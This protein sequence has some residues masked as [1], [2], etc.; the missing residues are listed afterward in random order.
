MKKMLTLLPSFFLMLTAVLHADAQP[1]PR[2]VTLYV[3]R[4]GNDSW[5]GT[6]QVPNPARTDGP[7]ATLLGA[8]NAVR[9][10]RSHNSRALPV[11]VV[12]ASGSYPQRQPVVFEPQ[13]GGTAQCPISYEAA[14]GAKPVFEAGV[15]INGFRRGAYGVWTANVPDV[16][17]GALYFEQLYIN[18]RR[19]TRARLPK[20]F[21]YF[22]RGKY[23][24]GIDPLTGKEAALGGRA[25]VADAK[26]FAPLLRVPQDRLRDVEFIAYHSWEASWHRIAGL[27][28][29]AHAI[30]AMPP[31]AP[32]AFL[33]WAPNQR[34][35]IENL[36]EA[37]TDPGEWYLDRDG[38]LSY[39]PLPGEDMTK[40]QIY[41]PIGEQ[42][43]RFEG[44][45]AHKV[46]Y[47]TLKGLA[48]RHGGY[49]LPPEG[50]GDGQAAVGISAV[51]MADHA[52]HIIVR[53]CEITNVGLYGIWFRRGCTECRVQHTLFQDL[54]AG[55][56]RIG[57]DG[58]DAPPDEAD[59]TGHITLD[60]NIIRSGGRI[61]PGCIGVWIG[62]S[63]DNQ[64]IHNDIS[65]LYYT[66]ISVGWR[67]GYAPSVAKRN[68]IEFNH[69]H[70][71]GQGVMSDMGGVYT[72]GP[73]EGTTVSN[74]VIHD[75]YSY[76]R[77][78]RGGWGLYNDEGSTGI[79]EE[80][81]LVYNVKTGMYH[82]HYGR[83]NLLRNNIFAYSMDG[84]LQ[85]SRVEDHLS[86][87]LSH[88]IILWKESPLLSGSWGDA[89]VK[90]DHNLYWNSSGAKV[91][92]AG[93]TL[94]EWQATG[95]DEGSRVA[96]PDFVAPE[97]GDFRLKPGSP[98][99]QMGFKPFD[100][101]H[102]GVYGDA[103]WIKQA[104]SW[105][106]PPVRF[107]PPPPPSPPLAIHQDFER[108]PIGAPCPDAQNN[109]EGKGDSITVTDETANSGKRSLK[110][111][112]AP[113]L[114]FDFNPHLVF[115]PDHQAGVTTMKFAIRVEAG[116]FMYHEWRDWR[117]APY[118]VGPTF[119]IRNGVLTAAG[120]ELMPIPAGK[121]VEYT[122]RADVGPQQN[123]VWEL[124]VH[125]QGK[126]EHRFTDLPLGSR[127][128]RVL[129]WIGFS[130]MAT[131]RTVFYLD[132]IDLTSSK[133]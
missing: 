81:N 116:V 9:A 129:T 18:G 93:K 36:R 91:D 57:E 74:N 85:R 12:F 1:P 14:P 29:K 64:V 27:D 77:Y 60:N 32:W 89:N 35:V 88:N 83:E 66:G 3:A 4:N 70:H 78:G 56:A 58:G 51:V 124:T 37:L 46:A 34:Y 102:A 39:I 107:A 7:L 68:R 128:F 21:Y 125:V 120:R 6:K 41:A 49:T 119:T 100:Y 69:I 71:I 76:D 55:G 22:M 130:S 50:H 118:K 108:V 121:W 20:R 72:L 54:G 2:S 127:D 117:T 47:I 109:V 65:D 82:Q 95:K 8:R 23:E 104:R 110:I 111:T 16:R 86:F 98:A 52:Q 122:V 113:G 40:A 99:L 24:Y 44:T 123:G 131:E 59:R 38:T 53:D 13:D 114:Q 106:Y 5:S 105:S 97:H 15:R 25:F 26:E 63:G 42:F 126:P 43:A 103:A 115:S 112:D 28:V 92:F 61:F 79:V 73:S 67:W 101:T 17:R 132:D 94:A 45:A 96:D 10:W 31:G 19:A 133:P 84:Q 30:I 90:L 62:H 80:N 33:Q 11:R 87:T 48:Y 75:V